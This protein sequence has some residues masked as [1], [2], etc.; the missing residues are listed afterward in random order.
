M[1]FKHSLKHSFIRLVDRTLS[2]RVRVDLGVKGMKGVLH[3]RQSSSIT[4]NS[5]A[6]CLVLNPGYSSGEVLTFWKDTVRLF[7]SPS[8]LGQV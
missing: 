1:Q 5:P 7:Y 3:I 2:R 8:K 6:D 4:G